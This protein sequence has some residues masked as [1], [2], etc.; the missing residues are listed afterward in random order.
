MERKLL[1]LVGATI[2]I[3][4][5]VGV[6]SDDSF[7]C[8]MGGWKALRQVILCD[9][10]CCLGYA[11]KFIQSPFLTPAI[12][13]EK[14]PTFENHMKKVKESW[15]RSPYRRQTDSK[16]TAQREPE[17]NFLKSQRENF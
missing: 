1:T 15:F 3:S 11:E 14:S 2:L 13:C 17:I 16:K 7:T 9:A 4:I 10:P 8:C 5:G 12:F 6:T